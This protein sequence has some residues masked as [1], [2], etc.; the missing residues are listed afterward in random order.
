MLLTWNIMCEVPCPG[1]AFD[2]CVCDRR[3]LTH[4][5]CDFFFFF[6]VSRTFTVWLRGITSWKFLLCWKPHQRNFEKPQLRVELEILCRREVKKGK[7]NG[8][9][10]FPSFSYNLSAN[11]W[12]PFIINNRMTDSR[13]L[14][15][16]SSKLEKNHVPKFILEDNVI[17]C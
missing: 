2:H 5:L 4:L 15:K 13:R 16:N 7:A 11:I 10:S 17:A 1:S 9:V 6:L 14:K 8:T 3:C 12:T